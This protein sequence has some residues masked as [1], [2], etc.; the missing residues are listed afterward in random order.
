MRCALLLHPTV[1]RKTAMAAAASLA[2]SPAVSLYCRLLASR[3]TVQSQY[4]GFLH[5]ARRFASTTTGDDSGA[6]KPKIVHYSKLGMDGFNDVK[7]NTAA[8]E[9]LENLEAKLDSLD[10]AEVEDVNYS[11]GVLTI[12]TSSRG[13]FI[14]NK[15]APNVQLWLS[16]PMSGP[17]HYDMVT[18]TSNGVETVYWRSDNDEHDLKERLE[19]ELSEVLDDSFQL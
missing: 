4:G 15:Q 19:A 1:T 16:S 14:I 10:S 2:S 5:T 13:T 17:H 12:E 3:M 7:Y 6:S 9:F 11:S 18:S 8:D